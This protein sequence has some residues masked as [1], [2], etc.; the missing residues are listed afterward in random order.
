MAVIAWEQ[1]GVCISLNIGLALRQMCV[2][3]RDDAGVRGTLGNL[4]LLGTNIM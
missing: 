4:P 3:L 1:C 2:A